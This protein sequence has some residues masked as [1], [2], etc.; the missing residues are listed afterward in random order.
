MQLLV[1]AL[2]AVAPLSPAFAQKDPPQVDQ[3]KVDAAISKGAE[4]LR[5]RVKEGLPPIDQA[6]D[7]NHSG[8]TYNELVIYT[9]VHAG[10]NRGDLDL[11]KLVAET[12]TKPPVHTYTGAIRAMAFEMYDPV[13]LKFDLIQCAQFLIDNQGQNGMWGYSRPVKL[14]ELPPVTYSPSK[15]P[16]KYTASGPGG[17]E[18]AGP[19]SPGNVSAGGGTSAERP[20]TTTV[21][22]QPPK[23]MVPRRAWG[24]PNDNS[25]TQYAILGLRA[26]M[27]IGV[28]PPPDCLSTTE[29]WLTDN[30]NDD[31]GWSYDTKGKE[32]YGSMTVG[33]VS[34]LAICVRNGTKPGDPSQDPRIKRGI[35]WLGKKLKFD[36]NPG[37]GNEWHYYWIYGVERAGSLAET[38]WFGDKPWYHEGATWLLANQNNN[39]TWGKEGSK[40]QRIL[41]TCWAILFLRRATKHFA[42]KK[43]YT[44]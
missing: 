37:K 32:S 42:P 38:E 36:G 12:R 7:G 40:G 28:I 44:Q 19:S 1:L 30:Q 8:S 35:D 6:G 29:K 9:L 16:P 27:A 18:A 17:G 10:V 21:K 31:G 13:K 25:N 22:K 2:V 41:D 39:G 33:G 4:W 26:S 43:V 14:P 24:Q 20:G 23:I 34:S 5:E 11:I 3:A 15:E